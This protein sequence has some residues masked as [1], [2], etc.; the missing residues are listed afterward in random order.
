V[1]ELGE[2]EGW[3]IIKQ[4]GRALVAPIARVGQTTASNA[5][6]AL[7]VHSCEGYLKTRQKTSAESLN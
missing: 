2:R 1:D 5:R 4:K 6:R 7:L 3:V